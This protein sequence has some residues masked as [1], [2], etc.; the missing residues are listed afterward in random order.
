MKSPFYASPF[1]AGLAAFLAAAVFAA[2]TNTYLYDE[3]RDDQVPRDRTLTLEGS[4]CT[5]SPNQVVRPIKII[6]A[7]DAS[8]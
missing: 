7:M 3:R 6:L 8:Q 2:C 4:F 1:K 5:P